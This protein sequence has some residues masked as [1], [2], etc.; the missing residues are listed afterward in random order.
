MKVPIY[1][2]AAQNEWLLRA[3]LTSPPR[4]KFTTEDPSPFTTAHRKAADHRYIKVEK[5][6]NFEYDHK[7]RIVTPEFA[8][9][10][11][12]GEPDTTVEYIAA[13]TVPWQTVVEFNAH[14]ALFEQWRFSGEGRR[15]KTTAD[16]EDWQQFLAGTAASA[17]G[18]RR[19]KGGVV[20]QALKI[21]RKA[22]V[23]QRWGLRRRG[24]G[25]SYREVAEKLTAAG[26]PTKQHDFKNASRD[27][28]PAVPE[29]VIPADAPGV[30]DLVL[31]LVELWPSLE[32]ERLVLDPPPRWLEETSDRPQ[33]DQVREADRSVTL[34][35]QRIVSI[36]DMK[37]PWGVVKLTPSPSSPTEGQEAAPHPVPRRPV[38]NLGAGLRPH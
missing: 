32:W 24:P 23:W 33:N 4:A 8:Q 26:Y 7:R 37:D 29:N 25:S 17:A 12:P 10:T 3:V 6:A 9:V 19:C 21:M 34:S 38:L 15:L 5:T 1:G 11:V 35:T 27:D 18:V 30:R 2:L 28:N 20:Q 14:R 16:W 22:Y 13:P 31:T 36:P